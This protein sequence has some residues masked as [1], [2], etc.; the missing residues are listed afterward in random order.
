ME[1]TPSAVTVDAPK[2]SEVHADTDSES[3][4]DFSASFKVPSESPKVHLN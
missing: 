2:E 3:E 4:Y 1:P